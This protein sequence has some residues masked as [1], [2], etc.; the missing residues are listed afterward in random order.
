MKDF[1]QIPMKIGMM[2]IIYE[3]EGCH[4]IDLSHGSVPSHKKQKQSFKDL[5]ARVS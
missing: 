5:L 2:Q 3:E 4:S 1:L